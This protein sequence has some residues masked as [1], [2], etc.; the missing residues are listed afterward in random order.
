MLINTFSHL[1]GIGPLTEK[2][3]WDAGIR[4][5]KDAV[6]WPDNIGKKAPA[7]QQGIK[8]SLVHLENKNAKYF[9][10]LLPASQHFRFFPEFRDTCVFLD[11]E[12]TGLESTSVITTIALYDGCTTRCYVQGKNLDDFM[13]DIDRYQ[14]IVTYNGKTFDLPFIQ[15]QF[16]CRLPHAHIDLRYILKSLG[17]AGGLKKCERAMGIGRQDLD[18]VDGYFAILLWEEYQKNNDPRALD[19]LLAYNIEDVINLETLMVK[20][21]NLKIRETCF[22]DSHTIPEPIKAVNP[23]KPDRQIIQKLKTAYY[24][25]QGF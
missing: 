8:T 21:Y 12:T 2:K 19:T 25:F 20:A 4:T 10:D 13:T 3:L 24:P 23:I 5:W 16:N 11:I 14:V 17:F 7:I 22:S 15:K 9:E 6:L 18:G 1:P